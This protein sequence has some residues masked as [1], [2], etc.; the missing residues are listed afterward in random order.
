[1]YLEFWKRQQFR[2]SYEW[3]LVDY[4]EESDLI[5]PEFE[6]VVKT[7]RL[8]PVTRQKEPYLGDKQRYSRTALS[9]VTVIFWVS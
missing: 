9:L 7:E 4:D 8:N 3:D 1:M 6:A 2:L 5:R